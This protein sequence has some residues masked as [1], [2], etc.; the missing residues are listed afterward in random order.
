MK[1]QIEL[2]APR[3]LTRVPSRRTRIAL[4]TVAALTIAVPV[5]W[6]SDVFAD[7]PPGAFYHDAASAMRTSGITA[8]C[9][10][11]NAAQPIFCPDN[12]VTRAQMATFMHRGFGRVAF[13][14]G[15]NVAVT[16]TTDVDLATLTVNVPGATGA[17][18]F[19][20]LDA[21]VMAF[22]SDA[23]GCPC[24]ARFYITRDGGGG[25]DVRYVETATPGPSG[26]SID[27]GANTYVAAVPSGTTQTFRLKAG[28]FASTT[29][30]MTVRGSLSLITSP[31]GKT[32]SNALATQ[33]G[34]SGP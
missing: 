18:Q 21:T 31:F 30:S 28:R 8:G 11:N 27:S 19:V 5:A 2:N 25:S 6:A 16:S 15:S 4:A 23:T 26:F 14:Q 34:S 24:Q 1:I 20:K 3:W 9:G 13:T 22:A 12:E 32:G 7:V 33:G 29:G 17:T 10:Q